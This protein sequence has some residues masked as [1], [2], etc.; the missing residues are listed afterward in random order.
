M[1]L[2]SIMIELGIT[3]ALL[4]ALLVPSNGEKAR[5][6]RSPRLKHWEMFA[7]TR[8]VEA[9][10]CS[11]LNVAQRFS[12]GYSAPRAAESRGDGRDAAPRARMQMIA[13]MRQ[14]FSIK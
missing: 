6:L 13:R 8:V 4:V 3:N 1:V 11:R 10:R 5:C 14:I 7:I 2:T 9:R 12:A